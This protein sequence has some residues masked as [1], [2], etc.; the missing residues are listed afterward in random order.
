MTKKNIL[1]IGGGSIG[2]RHVRCFQQTARV[3]VSL[4]EINPEVRAGVSEKYSLARSFSTLEEAMASSPE[5]AVIATPAHLHV[6]MATQLASHGSHILIEKP[7][8]TT[9]NG[10][11]SLIQTV[12]KNNRIAAVA[13]VQRAHPVIASMRDA[14]G[15]GSFGAPVQM[16]AIG[17]QHFPTYRP[18]YR[19]IY[20]TDHRTGGGAIQDALTHLINT[21]EWLLGPVSE[22]TADAAHQVL[23][24]VEVEDTV[25][26]LARQG[27][28]LSAYSL[29]QHQAPNETTIT[30]ICKSGTVRASLHKNQWHYMTKPDT[31]W[32]QGGEAHLDRDGIFVQQAHAF[33]DAVEGKAPPL[34]TLSEG[35]QTLRVNLAILQAASERQWHTIDPGAAN[36]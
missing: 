24:G 23:E 3:T 5:M 1:I 27:G 19:E 2:E 30:V 22:L 33:L 16:V 29:N 12:K 32:Q 26:V 20:Y 9:T 34:C 21:G 17:G 25:H 10:I 36:E 6:D 4:C 28:A 8:S 15:S 31:P 18:A 35:L 11:H 14:I 7:L 13:Y